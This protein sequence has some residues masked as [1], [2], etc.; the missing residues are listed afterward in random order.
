MNLSTVHGR[1]K[2]GVRNSR[3][4]KDRRHNSVTGA[5][6]R[7]ARHELL[8]VRLDPHDGEGPWLDHYLDDTEARTS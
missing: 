8:E 4:R 1:K 6:A 2:H 7:I 5:D 3:L